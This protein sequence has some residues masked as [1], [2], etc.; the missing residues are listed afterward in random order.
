MEDKILQLLHG[1]VEKTINHNPSAQLF[2][3]SGLSFSLTDR[4]LSYVLNGHPV[5]HNGTEIDVLVFD[6]SY[7]HPASPG[8]VDEA[9]AIRMRNDAS[10]HFLLLTPHGAGAIAMS[11]DTAVETIGIG[12]GSYS[13]IDELASTELYREL[14]NFVAPASSDEGK[15]IQGIAKEAVGELL[16]TEGLSVDSVW[17]FISGFCDVAQE[18]G[19]GLS[20]A[21]AYCGCPCSAGVPLAK[22]T[23]L[24]KDF[25]KVFGE[26]ISDAV[27]FDE[28][29]GA[30]LDSAE[31]GRVAYCEEQVEEFKRF[32]ERELPKIDKTPYLAFGEKF[33][34]ERAF[35]SW[36]P[37]ITVQEIIR[38]IRGNE[39]KS[40][41][42]VAADGQLC[43]DTA[44]KKQP[45]LFVGKA[46]FTIQSQSNVAD[47]LFVKKGKNASPPIFSE[48]IN[49]GDTSRFEYVPDEDD[50]KKG[51]S[52]KFFFGSRQTRKIVSCDV[53][54][55][56]CLK[57]GM[58]MTLKESG[59]IHKIKP[60]KIPNKRLSKTYRT[61]ITV[62]SPGD[63]Q[64]QLFVNG[65]SRVLLTQVEY[66]DA[67]GER[68]Y[69]NFQDEH[70]EVRQYTFR[71][72]VYN[73]LRFKF[74][75]F[76]NGEEY[77]YEVVF[78]VKEGKPST[79]TS[80][81]Y[82][83]EH[84]RRNLLRCAGPVPCGEFQEVVL[85][86]GR[87]IYAIERILLA[88]A[89]AGNGGYPVVLSDDY[90]HVLLAAE[91]QDFS[92]P[93]SYTDKPF[94]T[95]TD[96]RPT[97]AEWKR[98]CA[99]YGQKY[100]ELR[101]KV[102]SLLETEYPEKCIEEIDFAHVSGELAQLIKDYADA[103]REWL[104]S[105]YVN[106]VISETIWVFPIRENQRLTEVP[107]QVIIPP[108]HPLRLAW[109]LWAQRLMGE[110]E[111]ERPSSA[112]A[113]FDSDAI[114]DMMCLPVAAIDVSERN[115]RY[116]PLF[117][118][119]STSRYWA[120]LHSY[121]TP[122][123]DIKKNE[124]L[125][126]EQFGLAFEKSSRTITKEQV[127]SALNDAR[128]MCMAKPSLSISFNGTSS[129][130]VC[131]EGILSWNRQFIEEENDQI[132][133]LGPRRL[134][135]Y[136]V[137][138][139]NLP[140]NETIAAISDQSEGSIQWYA[141][142]ALTDQMDLSIATLAAHECTVRESTLG[143]SVTVAGGLAC[144]RARQLCRG[145]YVIESRR[146]TAVC[147]WREDDTQL[148]RVISGILSGIST[149]AEAVSRGLHFHVG[150][151]TDVN[152]L[153]SNEKASYYAVS[154]ADVD[155]ACFVTGGGDAY[156]WDYR[157]PQGTLGSRNTEGF[158]L[159]ARETPVM[160]KAVAKAIESISNGG[161]SISDGVIANTLHLTAQRGIPTI[162]DLTLGGTKA[163]GEVGI[164]VAVSILQGD[165]TDSL[166]HGLLP[167]YLEDGDKAWL[168]FVVPFDPFRRQFEALVPAAEKKVR[169]DL[170]CISVRASKTSGS[171]D[172][173]AVKFTLIEVKTRTNKFLDTEKAHAL[174]QYA[175]CIKVVRSAFESK[176]LN[177]QTLAVYD[178]LVGLFTFGYRVYGTFKGVAE[179]ALDDFYTKT[180]SRMFSDR[181]F[182]TVEGDPRLIVVDS[183][184]TMAMDKRNGVYCTMRLNGEE[185][186]KAIASSSEIQIPSAIPAN[187]SMLAPEPKQ[188]GAT[189]DVVDTPSA[190][191]ADK[192]SAVE[193]AS[194]DAINVDIPVSPAADREEPAV[195][196]PADQP[197][198][199]ST[200]PGALSNPADFT[201][202]DAVQNEIETAQA[203]LLLALSEAQIHGD[204]IGTPK[205]A[206]NSF[207]FTFSGRHPSMSPA[208]IQNKTTD[209]KVH[210][211]IEILRVVAKPLMVSVHVK[212]E[213]REPID[214]TKYW[215]RTE[216]ECRRDKKLF[217]G[218]AE[219]DGR[220][221]FLDPISDHA[222][223]TLVAG[224]T[225]SGKSVLLRNLL[226]SIGEIFTPLESR[227]ILIDPKKGQDYFAFDGMPHFYG[228]ENENV[229]IGTQERASAVLGDLV[230][231]MERRVEVLTRA[232]CEDL[233]QYQEKIGDP[234]SPDWIPR[235]W[236]FHDEFA[237][238]MLDRDYKR[239]VENT[240]SQLAVMARSAGIHLVFAT[241]RPSAEVVSVQTRN[242]L[243]NRLILKV[244]DEGTSNIAI[245]K[246]G[247]ESLLGQG[248]I[249]IR[250]EGEDG[251]DAVEG[252]VAF[253]D[254]VN[255]ER[256]VREII[257]RYEAI[258]VPD[259]MVIHRD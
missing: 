138:G 68:Q 146:T 131:R 84:I 161:S 249:L 134:K 168:N 67:Q 149:P 185:S 204:L 10:H 203:A 87:D 208:S 167:P 250:R 145:S 184:E 61:E 1:Y 238:W 51:K 116:L 86:A 117:S 259:A 19:V 245:G 158:Y 212:R 4:F 237:M 252:Q 18:G 213:H 190:A 174:D 30:L 201:I 205:V 106:A 254:K 125:W 144:Y 133:Q 152:S 191:G 16:R 29:F 255:V 175:T 129:Q 89:T 142:S 45:I 239:L 48:T 247:A 233:K 22:A 244:A 40:A 257:R 71:I 188:S 80:E 6:P 28:L 47:E 65:N 91:K 183:G 170:V 42:I 20:T 215:P 155:H 180:V 162:K 195:S 77:T 62:L 128:E 99:T 55:L 41:L 226:Y 3:F 232:R 150:F 193:D 108:M 13:G 227:I 97:F 118:V 228:S 126:N 231:E 119:R 236:V 79:D 21:E 211:G 151:P 140:T 44:N 166:R 148:P 39:D 206:P 130:G 246:P 66:D 258:Q 154:S 223:H 229:W 101:Q 241:Q 178:F 230:Q 171:L 95:G 14:M 82:Y 159:L 172:P 127:E 98:S 56:D 196:N 46:R 135:I 200:V 53:M 109:M 113:V 123:V 73:E 31:E 242:N 164:L 240:I 137:G 75:G 24:Q 235:L 176:K 12:E 189:D 81:T 2:C 221:L 105:D 43:G 112:V 120:V 153:V 217:I 216:A 165:I 186:C 192:P 50:K 74:K 64:G 100:R 83:D 78:Y 222:P 34:V 202:S 94:G 187:W 69:F 52:S 17:D 8:Y 243:G 104:V 35:H 207:V 7:R 110:A 169:P 49:P 194:P 115:V 27:V 199:V 72:N 58:H 141:P 219:E 182:V 157:L 156:L 132:N 163:L 210:H 36:W 209:F 214:W 143:N 218:L 25:Y 26:A 198:V 59:N 160:F 147:D 107:S 57:A 124:N 225:R 139:A 256:G 179:L 85:P 38:I 136:D 37:D 92:L 248:H 96:T 76:S 70:S 9:G 114:P 11:M 32:V 15:Y 177:L 122:S 60:F 111:Q 251:D 23:K 234:A 90:R 54:L 220:C 253:H 88:E 197:S 102:F 33:R 93:V 103:Y 181:N 173:Q 5:R 224:A 63:V 121:D